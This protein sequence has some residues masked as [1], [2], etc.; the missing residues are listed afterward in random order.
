[1]KAKKT[2]WITGASSGIGNVLAQS[3]I[4]EGHFVVVSGRNLGALKKLQQLSPGRVGL[5]DFDMANNDDFANL[6]KRMGELTDSLDMVVLAAGVCEYVNNPSCSESLYRRVME[7][8]FFAQV[9]C[10][11]L[12]LPLLSR[13]EHRAQI[14]GVGS[15]AAMLPFPRAE[16]YGASKAA[17]EYWMNSLRI[18]LAPHKIDVTLVSPGF[19]DT[20]LTQK[21]DFEMPTLMTLEQACPI[22]KRG[23]ESRKRHVRFPRSLHW[24]L[25][26]LANIEWLWYQLVA[27]RLSRNSKL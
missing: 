23:I 26:L 24:S 3:F 12:A 22:I 4:E 8:N 14:V 13:S 20:P 6:D 17:F 18:D 27:P 7:V 19:V 10:F 1:M 2:I 5:L 9:R 25:A 16:A 15:L 11:N 21:N